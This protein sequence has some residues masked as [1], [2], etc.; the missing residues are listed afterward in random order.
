MRGLFGPKIFRENAVIRHMNPEKMDMRFQVTAPHE[1]VVL[2]CTAIALLLVFVWS[3]AGSM[4]RKL[5]AAGILILSGERHA[6]FSTLPGMLQTKLV[7]VGDTIE[8]GH[9]VAR[10]N[11][12]AVNLHK[13]LAGIRAEILEA[14]A[15]MD[16]PAVSRV[17]NSLLAAQDELDSLTFVK[18]A[19][20]VVRS[21]YA[22]EVSA[23][24]VEQGQSVPASAAIA[25]IRTDADKKLEVVALIPPQDAESLKI[26][27]DARVLF[28]LENGSTIHRSPAK[29]THIS[30]RTGTL[31]GWL[32]RLGFQ[33][34]TGPRGHLVY[35]VLEGDAP[36]VFSDGVPCTVEL[37]LGTSS[38]LGL[39]LGPGQ[40]Q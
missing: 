2:A 32:T 31:P 37:A 16:A 13:R 9:P 14:T 5:S 36:E 11:L 12:H 40:T 34:R 19:S 3:I 10:V 18:A 8:A 29:V 33:P 21:P 24:Y 7:K 30:A 4:E 26:G 28:Y 39:L 22:G 1:W 38:P 27:M 17:T 23:F 15:D 35:L 6:V 20:E 25:E